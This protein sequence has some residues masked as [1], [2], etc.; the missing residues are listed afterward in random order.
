[1]K[2]LQS[3]LLRRCGRRVRG[4]DLWLMWLTLEWTV[5]IAEDMDTSGQW[6]ML[7]GL[8]DEGGQVGWGASHLTSID[9]P[10]SNWILR[11]C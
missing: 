6:S 5:N 1:M 10:M 8:G 9:M 3:R 2:G 7:E 11:E 4:R